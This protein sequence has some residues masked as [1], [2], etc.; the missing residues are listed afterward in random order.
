MGSSPRNY[1]FFA[2]KMLSLSGC[3]LPIL[4]LTHWKLEERYLST[5]VRL[6][7]GSRLVLIHADTDA[8]F[9]YIVFTKITFLFMPISQFPC[10]LSHQMKMLTG[11]WDISYHL[12]SWIWAARFHLALDFLMCSWADRQVKRPAIIS[13][14]G[15]WETY[16]KSLSES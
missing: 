13:S 9:Y 15:R 12:H 14:P 4:F 3:I 7:E 6:A 11:N 2:M 16:W 8:F 5:A 1:I 10:F